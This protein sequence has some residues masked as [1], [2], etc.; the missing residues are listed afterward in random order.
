MIIEGMTS[1]RAVIKAIREN[2]SDRKI[3]RIFIDSERAVKRAADIRWLTSVSGEFGFR[4]ERLGAG[5]FASLTEG[6]THGGIA[7]EVSE[8]TFPALRDAEIPEKGFF[9]MLEGIEDPFNFGDAVRS[10]Y[11]CGCDCLVMR[12]RNWMSA[13]STVMK[14]SAGTSELIRAVTAE[15]E[16]ACGLLKGRGYRTVCAGIRD[17]VPCH[18]ADLSRPLLL[19]I[20]GEKRGISS[21]VTASADLVVRVDYARGF[22]GS[23]SASA[24]AAMLSY[25]IMRQNT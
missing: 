12:E 9:A 3:S 8:R 5:E 23:L 10:L 11:L 17:S 2:G 21:Q 13:A 1:V 24:A 19:V 16:E 20:G 25:E 7:A 14:A 4:L 22:R 18:E 6:K 15:P